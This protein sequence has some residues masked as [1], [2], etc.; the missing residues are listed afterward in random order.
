MSMAGPELAPVVPIG[1]DEHVREV[2]GRAI[3]EERL[4]AYVA[5]AARS[6]WRASAWLLE[7]RY[8]QR[9]GPVRAQAESDVPVVV[10]GDDPFAE[11]DMLAA[12]RRARRK[13]ER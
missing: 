7:R 10:S 9:W 2:I 1:D 6:N 8:P 3:A 13:G 5:Q 4:V 12:R 11:V